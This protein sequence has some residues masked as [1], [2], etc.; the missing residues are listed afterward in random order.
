[1]NYIVL[2]QTPDPVDLE[3]SVNAVKTFWES[4]GFTTRTETNSKDPGLIR[5]YADQNGGQLMSYYANTKGSGLEIDTVCIAGDLGAMYE[6]LD[7]Q[8]ASAS[9]TPTTK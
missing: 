6:E 5:L 9:P 2:S 7:R 1:M 8:D 3:A 4:K